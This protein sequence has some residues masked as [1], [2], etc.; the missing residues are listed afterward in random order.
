LV[1]DAR[2]VPL[3]VTVTAGQRDDSTQF[4]AAMEAAHFPRRP[5]S[6]RPRRIGG[7][8]GY[9]ASRIRLWIGRRE[10]DAVIPYRQGQRR[11]SDSPDEELDRE[12]Y[13]GR[14]VVE[15]CVG[16]LKRARRIA[17]RF[18]K[19]ALCFLAMLKLAILGRY[20]RIAFRNTT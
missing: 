13:R 6:R 1:T 18:E 12:S 3:G 8:R 4:E 10:I 15:R 9:S 19:L 11:Q 14:N 17:T 5:G 16:W 20:L 7:D 2:G